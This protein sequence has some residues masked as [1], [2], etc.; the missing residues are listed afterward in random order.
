[1]RDQILVTLPATDA[2]SQFGTRIRVALNLVDRT[3]RELPGSWANWPFRELQ[4]PDLLDRGQHK[5]FPSA[6][7]SVPGEVILSPH[8]Y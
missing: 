2:S 1:M 4:S 3:Y 5:V 6:R 7:Y 8:Q